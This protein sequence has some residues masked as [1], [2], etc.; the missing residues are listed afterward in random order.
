MAG[1]KKSFEFQQLIVGVSSRDVH[2]ALYVCWIIGSEHLYNR[3]ESLYVNNP[4]SVRQD[5]SRGCTD[6]ATNPQGML[7][8]VYSLIRSNKQHRRAFLKALLRYFEDY[9]VRSTLR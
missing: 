5:V 8:H 6:S 3:L 2:N 7:A 4:L 1:V 9:E